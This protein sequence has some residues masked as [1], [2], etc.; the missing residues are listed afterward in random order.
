MQSV[1]TVAAMTPSLVG[2]AGAGDAVAAAGSQIAH[3]PVGSD[4]VG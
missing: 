1:F 3:G 4:R 2:F